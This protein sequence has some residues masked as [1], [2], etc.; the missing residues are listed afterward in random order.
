M[1]LKT[2]YDVGD[3]PH[4]EYPRPQMERDSFLCLNGYWDL[5]LKKG[6]DL[7]AVGNILVPFSPETLNSTIPNGFVLDKKDI[8]VY[9]REFEIDESYMRGATVL[10]FGAVDSYC[11]VYI[12]DKFVGDHRGGYTP[13]DIDI[14]CE[15]EK[16]KNDIR[17]ECIDTTE[18]S[19]GARGKQSSTPGTIWYTAQS[20]IWQTV[21]IESMPKKYI[22]DITIKTDTVKKSVTIF[23][24]YKGEQTATF[25]DGDTTIATLKFENTLT[26][27][28]DFELWSP[29]SPKLY[30]LQIETDSGDNVKTYFGVRSFGISKDSQGKA[31]L[32]LNDKPYFFNGLLDQGYWSDGL[33]TPPSDEAMLDEIKLLKDM[34]FNMIRKHI[35]LEPMRWYY[36][37]DR[38]GIVVWQD[39]VNGGG[40]YKFMKIAALPFLGFKHRD[41]DYAYFAR[42][43]EQGRKEYETALYETI[44]AL[45]NCTCIGVWVPFNEGWG[46][47]DSAKYTQLIK[48]IDDTRVIDSVS[49]WYDQGVGKTELR[50]LHTYYTK[51]KVPKDTRPVVLSEFG[52]YSLKIDG[53][54]FNEKKSFGYKI[55]K[56]EEEFAEAIEELYLDRILPLIKKGLC[57]CVYTQVSDVEE[58]INGLVTYDREYIKISPQ[59]MRAINQKIANEADKIN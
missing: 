17:V 43:N 21:W 32:T 44:G 5:K 4:S 10:H 22:K 9:T 20:G 16:G 31:R 58:E 42:E 19:C 7:I 52:G 50:S 49:G 18:D 53:H 1:V 27:E 33:L 29:E 3:I 30:Y 36:H 39:L 15:I 6:E 57:A 14:T 40:E 59:R 26:F 48:S 11:R 8:L 56:N 54:V 13:F 46:Q 34:G 37:C 12:N 47:F 55:Y 2:R 45:K 28:Y 25:F 35:K 51:L 23:S 24:D 38:L 41:D